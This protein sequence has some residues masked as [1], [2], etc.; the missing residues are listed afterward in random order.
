M[1]VDRTLDPE[2]NG[3]YGGRQAGIRVREGAGKSTV[4]HEVQH[5]IQDYSGFSRGSSMRKGAKWALLIS[6]QLVKR[7]PA[8]QALRTSAERFAYVQRAA[9]LRAPSQ[10]ME[11]AT[12]RYYENAA[13]EVEARNVAERANLSMDERKKRPPNIKGN[14]EYGKNPDPSF[15]DMLSEMCYSKEKIKQILKEGV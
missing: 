5:G 13:G 9:E 7:T 10:T 8:Y 6:Y 11:G 15:I 3:V 1:E 14:P 12:R 2:T 4:L